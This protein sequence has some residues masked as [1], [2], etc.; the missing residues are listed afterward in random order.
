M[1][2]RVPVSHADRQL[3]ELEMESAQGVTFDASKYQGWNTE[4]EAESRAEDA[5]IVLLVSAAP[6]HR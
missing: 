1:R 4:A 6:I 5:E 2:S 3:V